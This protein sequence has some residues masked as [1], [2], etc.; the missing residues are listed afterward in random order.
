MVM[1]QSRVTNEKTTEHLGKTF[2]PAILYICIRLGSKRKVHVRDLAGRHC[3]RVRRHA[4]MAFVRSS[5]ASS[6]CSFGLLFP[7][8]FVHILDVSVE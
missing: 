6:R 7:C 1:R 2:H 4:F 3:R 8:L 5:C